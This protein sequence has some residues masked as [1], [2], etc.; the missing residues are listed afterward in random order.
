MDTCL[1]KFLVRC[2]DVERKGEFNIAGRCNL[3]KL[4][5]SSLSLSRAYS[6]PFRFKGFA[7]CFNSS[8]GFVKQL[9]G[10]TP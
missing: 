6:F 9:F 5:P 2:T 8:F 1:N 7:S 4:R 3:V 10:A